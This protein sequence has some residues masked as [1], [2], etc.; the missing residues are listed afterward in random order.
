[1]P[2]PCATTHLGMHALRNTCSTGCSRNLAAQELSQR[3][4]LRNHHSSCRSHRRSSTQCSAEPAGCSTDRAVEQLVASVV[5]C[6]VPVSSYS[7]GEALTTVTG[8]SFACTSCGKC[9]SLADGAEVW[10]NSKELGAIAAHLGISTE[11]ATSQYLHPYD[12]VPGWHLLNSKTVQGPWPSDL[13]QTHQDRRQHLQRQVGHGGY[14]S[15]AVPSS[16]R[17]PEVQML[18]YQHARRQCRTPPSSVVELMQFDTTSRV[19]GPQQQH[20][21]CNFC[22]SCSKQWPCALWAP[23]LFTFPPLVHISRVVRTVQLAPLS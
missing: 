14:W 5:S 23:L 19:L 21:A 9:C 6:G 1:L 18:I 3:K 8:K 12:R 4:L 20:D 7:L 11:Q 13:P 10:L 15:P 22:G 17:F 16:I 2:Q